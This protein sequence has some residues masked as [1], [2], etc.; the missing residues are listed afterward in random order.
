MTMRKEVEKLKKMEEEARKG[1]GKGAIEK[2][3]AA[4][5]LTARERVDLLFDPGTFV[6]MNM[7]AQHQCHDFDMEKR[8]PLGDAVITGYGKIGGEPSLSMPRTSPSLV[9][10]SVTSMPPRYALL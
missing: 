7:F 2:Q 4:G 3:H 8:R 10:R 9:V 1:G 5:K 6:E